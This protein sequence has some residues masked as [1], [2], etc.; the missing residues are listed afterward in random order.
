MWTDQR[1]NCFKTCAVARSLEKENSRAWS[2][3]KDLFLAVGLQLQ[4][5]KTEI[6]RREE[7]EQRWENDTKGDSEAIIFFLF[8]PPPCSPSSHAFLLY[9]PGREKDD[10]RHRQNQI[11]ECWEGQ[12]CHWFP[13]R[14]KKKRGCSVSS[15]VCIKGHSSILEEKA[16]NGLEMEQKESQLTVFRK[17]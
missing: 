6:S 11:E 17:C 14:Q 10:R 16:S 1:T 8:F 5:W 4:L 9:F 2:N 12:K 3:V 7:K 13:S 15:W